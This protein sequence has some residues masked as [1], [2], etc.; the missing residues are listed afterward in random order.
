MN[1][2]ASVSLVVRK[3][4]QGNDN[5]RRALHAH[6]IDIHPE[7]ERIIRLIEEQGVK[8]LDTAPSE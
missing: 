8:Y 5:Y 1:E 2:A 3:F 6:V 7:R 4:I